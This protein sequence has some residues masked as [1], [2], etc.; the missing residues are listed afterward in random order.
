VANQTVTDGKSTAPFSKVSV[1]DS[2]GLTIQG[3]T[4][5]LYDSSSNY[6]NPTDA[7]GILSGPNLTKVG[8]GTYTVTPGSTA[9]VSAELNALVFTP[10]ISNTP[11]TT[12][13]TLEAFDGATTADNGDTSVIALLGPPVPEI[14]G[15]TAGQQILDNATIALFAAV[16]VTDPGAAPSD[17][18]TITLTDATSGLPTDANGSLSGAGLKHTNVGIYTLVST[19]PANLTAELQALVFT[20]TFNE[21]PTGNTV[22]TDFRLTVADTNGSVT[23]NT[24]SVVATASA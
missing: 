1:T 11:A 4:I 18:A 8:V 14:T 19:N 12:D 10:T 16:S 5:V 21:V 24:T 22:T 6:L 7:N 20:P 3:T 17:S 15:T 13:F 9:A 23:D 2:A